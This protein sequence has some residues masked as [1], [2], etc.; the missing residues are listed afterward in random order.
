MS[1]NGYGITTCSNPKNTQN[2]VPIGHNMYGKP[3]F[4]CPARVSKDS[5]ITETHLKVSEEVAIMY[6]KATFRNIGGSVEG[7]EICDGKLNLLKMDRSEFIKKGEF[8]ECLMTP[9][10]SNSELTQLKN[11][12]LFNEYFSGL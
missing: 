4:G 11:C 2:F 7:V 10:F 5:I 8:P 1:D 9:H 6:V 3:I 12:G